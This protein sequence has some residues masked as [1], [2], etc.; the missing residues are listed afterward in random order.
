MLCILGP[1]CSH[2]FLTTCTT[3][4]VAR[5]PVG[6]QV[7]VQ[8]VDSGHTLVVREVDQ[9]D[10]IDDLL[11]D[12]VQEGAHQVAVGVDDYDG[13]VVL[14]LGLRFQ[15]VGDHVLHECGLSHAGLG[16]VEVVLP[17]QVAGE[18]DGPL[19]AAG[20]SLADGRSLPD[21][22]R[23]GVDGACA[24]AFQQGHLVASP[25]HVPQGGHLAGVEHAA[26]PPGPVCHHRQRVLGDGE[27]T[28]IEA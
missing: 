5:S 8:Q 24:G 14:S 16:D 23:Q 1:H 28:D 4:S 12:K 11:W 2:R 20:D 13:V 26:T 17:E 25:G 7:R 10:L 9:V 27:I 19:A 6:E 18:V 3:L 21:A 15:L 22:P